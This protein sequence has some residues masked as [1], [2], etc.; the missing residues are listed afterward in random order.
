VDAARP[1]VALL[2]A[3]AFAVGPSATSIHGTS[4]GARADTL[5]PVGLAAQVRGTPNLTPTPQIA[6]PPP[7]GPSAGPNTNGGNLPTRLPN[8]GVDARLLGLA[9]IALLLSGIGLRMRIADDLR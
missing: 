5:A 3:G 1:I 7:S 2:A 8:T 4:R 9:G 6:P